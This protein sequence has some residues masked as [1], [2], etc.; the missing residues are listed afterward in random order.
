MES[1]YG[2]LNF[3]DTDLWRELA[4][5]TST[6]GNRFLLPT[7]WR[8]ISYTRDLADSENG[9]INFVDTDLWRGKPCAMSFVKE[10]KPSKIARNTRGATTYLV[11]E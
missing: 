7:P 5:I 10:K 11:H 1:E 4:W 6:T 8:V 2:R 9:R 3:V